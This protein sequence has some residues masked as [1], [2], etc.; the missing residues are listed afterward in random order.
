MR[1]RASVVCPL[2][3]AQLPI[4]RSEQPGG[5]P[6][7]PFF[8]YRAHHCYPC[9]PRLIRRDAIWPHWIETSA[10]SA[11]GLRVRARALNAVTSSSA[12][13]PS[14]SPSLNREPL[15]RRRPA[16]LIYEG[17][18]PSFH[19]RRSCNSDPYNLHQLLRVLFPFSL[20][21]HLAPLS[22]RSIK[23]GGRERERELGRYHLT[24]IETCSRAL[25][26]VCWKICF[27]RLLILPSNRISQ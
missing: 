20:R 19:S 6:T 4:P 7:G 11:D 21:P 8:P 15:R 13:L 9:S 17:A 10:I 24:D 1:D 3:R 18:L 12:I 5:K 27:F 14:E 16:R 23:K 22:Q 25:F 2:H 26:E